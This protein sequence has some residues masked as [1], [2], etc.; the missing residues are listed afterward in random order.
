MVEPQKLVVPYGTA[1]HQAIAAGDVRRMRKIAQQVETWLG[2]HGD[3]GAAL[4]LL[5]SEIARREAS[6]A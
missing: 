3:I 5:K 1:I 2:Q 6:R 4:E